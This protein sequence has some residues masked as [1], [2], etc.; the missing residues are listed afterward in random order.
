MRA[1]HSQ[2]LVARS[3]QSSGGECTVLRGHRETHQ[4]QGHPSNTT[5]GPAACGISDPALTHSRA[6][7]TAD[8]CCCPQ[9]GDTNTLGCSK[10]CSSSCATL[11]NLGKEFC[12]NLHFQAADGSFNKFLP[13]CHQGGRGEDGEGL[14]GAPGTPLGQLLASV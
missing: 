3:V 5:A 2:F 11:G 14:Q 7:T 9:R 8:F 6:A 10:M 13:G 12:G 1:N 4:L